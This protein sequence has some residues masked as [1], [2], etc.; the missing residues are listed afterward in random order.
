MILEEQV[1]ILVNYNYLKYNLDSN[2]S[3]NNK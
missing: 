1:R 3:N 2:M